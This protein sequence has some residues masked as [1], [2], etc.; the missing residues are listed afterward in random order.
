MQANGAAEPRHQGMVFLCFTC[1][2]GELDEPFTERVIEGS[3]LGASHLAGL[4]D[5]IVV[6]AKSNVFHTKAVYTNFV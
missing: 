5:E 3:L 4:V 1:L 2:L 6:R